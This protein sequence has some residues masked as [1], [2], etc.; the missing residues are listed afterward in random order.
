MDVD[1]PRGYFEYAP[2]KNLRKENAWLKEAVG[3]AVKI[4][5]PLM[6]SLKPGLNYCV[7][8]VERETVKPTG[9]DT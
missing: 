9:D 5:A 3:K 4:V 1:N 7:L 6:G 2:V 8:M